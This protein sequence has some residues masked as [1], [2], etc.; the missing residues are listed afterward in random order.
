[1]GITKVEYYQDNQLLGTKTVAPF[2]SYT[3]Q[4][5]T[6]G[7]YNLTAKVFYDGQLSGTSQPVNVNVVS[8][9][10]PIQGLVADY[11]FDET[12]G[13]LIDSVNG[14]NG[15]LNGDIVRN[16][17]DYQFNAINTYLDLASPDDFSMVDSNSNGVDFTMRIT[18]DLKSLGSD[19]VFN[20]RDD[21]YSEAEYALYFSNGI[22][23]FFV[24][25][26]NSKI[27]RSEVNIN[28][29]TKYHIVIVYKSVSNELLMYINKDASN[30]LNTYDPNFSK[31]Q[32]HTHPLQIGRLNK[33]GGERYINGN[34]YNFRIHKG[35]A[36]T[37]NDIDND[38]NQVM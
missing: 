5:V 24:L 27:L 20:K 9:T 14:Y 37:Q 25:D 36:W 4:G 15:T 10:T 8:Q 18:L 32:K 33:N 23:S 19:W 7:N 2:D 6:E 22:L 12:S 3:W 38:Y 17:D 16:G 34:I 26:G 31:P 21:N 30:T 13:D 28:E 11:Q 29:N 1:M 35:Y